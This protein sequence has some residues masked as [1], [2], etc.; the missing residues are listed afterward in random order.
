M[1][2]ICSTDDFCCQNI[3]SLIRLEF[4]L[5]SFPYSS[6]L[7]TVC[8]NFNILLRHSD[9]LVAGSL[10]RTAYIGYNILKI[11][12]LPF[13]PEIFSFLSSSFSCVD[14]ESLEFCSLIDASDGERFKFSLLSEI[15]LRKNRLILQYFHSTK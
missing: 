4:F 8:N 1:Q 12:D 10:I 5:S 6:L 9:M 14:Q 15:L 13:L 3:F 7:M 11:L 2:L